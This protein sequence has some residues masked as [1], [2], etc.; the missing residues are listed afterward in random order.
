[1]TTG[2]LVHF[3]KKIIH[4][5]SGNIT[6]RQMQ[7]GDIRRVL[8]IEQKNFLIPWST[9]AFSFELKKNPHSLTLVAESDGKLI[10][11]SVSYILVDEMHLV[12][13]SVDKDFHR[14]KI[15]QL[16]LVTNIDYAKQRECQSITL[17]VRKSNWA[18]IG[19]Y[20][21]FGF[22]QTG[23]RRRYYEPNG[24]DALIMYKAIRSESSH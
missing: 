22:S 23:L 4:L 19:L 17:E 6:I 21:K 7:P 8:N 2:V 11:Y 9:R 24:E 3:K 10:G 1:M 13:L 20:Q 15:G 18:A 12:N 5:N 14:Q 16:L